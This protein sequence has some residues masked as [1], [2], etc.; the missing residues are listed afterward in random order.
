MGLST[1]HSRIIC[2]LIRVLQFTGCKTGQRQRKAEWATQDTFFLDSLQYLT[3]FFLLN[4][5]SLISHEKNNMI[6][7]EIPS[8]RFFVFFLQ[9]HCS[10]IRSNSCCGWVVAVE[11]WDLLASW[12]WEYT[13]IGRYTFLIC[14]Q[15]TNARSFCGYVLMIGGPPF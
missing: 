8:K 14:M 9:L 1:G 10:F 11:C 6:P 7:K 2:N 5:A 4:F 13:Y 3:F 12:G 15:M